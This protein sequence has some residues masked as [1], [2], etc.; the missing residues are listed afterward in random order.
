MISISEARRISL[1]ALGFSQ[2]RPSRA[3]ATHIARTIRRLG[4]VQI[5]AVNVLVR[6]QYLVL[7]S[8]LGPYDRK[9][10]DDVVYRSGQFTEQWAHEASILPVETWPLLRHRM[11]SFR[12]RPYGYE[13]FLADNAAYVTEVIQQVRDRGALIPADVKE[14]EGM[15]RRIPNAWMGT[16]PRVVLEAQFAR[17]VLAIADR[18]PGFV[19]A[20]DLAERVIPAEQFGRTIPVED[21]NREFIRQAARAYGIAIADDLADYF[22]M[23]MRDARPRI[24]EL[25]A[26]HE[27]ES[28]QV[29]GWKA[30]AYLH[31]EAYTPRK[32]EAAA[33]LSP[34]D[35]VVW[36][37]SRAS[38]LFHF[39][40]RIEI[41]TP[42]SQR[43]HGYY[44]LPFLLG[45]NL[46]ARVDLKAERKQGQLLVQS[47]HIEAGCKPADV[48]PPLASEL[49][50][51]ASW[52]HLDTI[53]V[54]TNNAFEK[55]LARAVAR[56]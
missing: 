44:V 45:E 13:K 38:R 56:V 10:F 1:A 33:L 7:F 19:R 54:R 42:E 6:A 49:R 21:A 24:A 34:F 28:V 14:P 26:A 23:P 29:E 46:V 4:L 48:A 35:P 43:K 9:R 36:R 2:S 32:I 12:I 55:T 50:T 3:N 30:P 15:A 22:R 27:L 11:A 17:G 31:P 41:Y 8:R 53:I 51:L 37:R 40:Y 47:A 25:V 16:I 18:R 20:Y 5:D 39:D 52:L